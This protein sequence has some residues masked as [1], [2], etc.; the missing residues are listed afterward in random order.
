MATI[1]QI[2][3][4]K[5]MRKTHPWRCGRITHYQVTTNGVSGH[6]V[7]TLPWYKFSETPHVGDGMENLVTP[8]YC[9]TTYDV[10]Y[11]IHKQN[12]R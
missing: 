11:K 12:V 5:K 7:Y 6:N 10:V 8:D 9:P 1:E 3:T 2:L 4:V